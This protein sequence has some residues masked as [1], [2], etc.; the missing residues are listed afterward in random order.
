MTAAT[1]N[2]L[3][4]VRQLVESRPLDRL[5]DHQLLE[6]F[7]ARREEAMFAPLVRRHGRGNSEMC[8]PDPEYPK[9]FQ[10]RP[11]ANL[12]YFGLNGVPGVFG[13]NSCKVLDG[14]GASCAK[15]KRRSR[16]RSGR[17]R[18]AMWAR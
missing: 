9:Y 5:T 18:R 7:V 4:H 14:S 1:T 2:L 11:D 8:V 12:G 10:T 17:A 16:S 15:R 3:R 6:G 13:G